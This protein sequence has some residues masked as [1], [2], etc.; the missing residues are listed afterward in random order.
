MGDLQRAQDEPDLAQASYR[1]SQAINDRLVQKE[2]GNA[3]NA[4]THLVALS[5]AASLDAGVRTI[6]GSARS[7]GVDVE[8]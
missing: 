4:V 7:M 8:G 3:A 6:A 5:T 2:P 1:A